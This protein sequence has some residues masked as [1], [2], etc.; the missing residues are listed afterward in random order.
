MPLKSLLKIYNMASNS[1]KVIGLMSGTSL[2]GL[3]IAYS[4]FEKQ[5]HNYTYSL[6]HSETIPYP[7]ALKNRLQNGHMLSAYDLSLLHIEYGKFMGDQ[8][9]KYI[10]R[11][12]IEPDFIASHGHT[13]FHDPLTNNHLQ[14]GSGAEIA[15][16]TSIDTICDFRSKDIALNGQGAPL[17]PIGDELLFSDY[18]CCLN[19]GGFSNISYRYQNARIAYDICPCNIALNHFAALLGLDYDKNGQIGKKGQVIDGMLKQL[20][21]IDFYTMS[22]PKSLG[23]E[24]FDRIFLGNIANYESHHK[25]ILRTLYEHIAFQIGLHISKDY[26]VLVTGGGALNTFLIERIKKYTQ[27][28]IYLPDKSLINYKEAII[29][30]L[31]G[32]LY[33][34]NTPNCISSVTGADRDTIGGALYKGK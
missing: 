14:I 2:D 15:A 8:C 9:L 1:F 22:P 16:I 28:K 34:E 17:V 6:F 27:G 26:N 11:H 5:H 19:L 7:P 31:L 23:K 25:N 21:E 4:H 29:F 32:V 20:N 30:G 12:T 24:W 3:D 10:H 13:V 33:K 18:D